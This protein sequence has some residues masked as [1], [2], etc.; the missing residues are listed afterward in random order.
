LALIQEQFILEVAEAVP[1]EVHEV[2]MVAVELVVFQVEIH[3]ELL[4]G[5]PILEVVAVEQTVKEKQAVLAY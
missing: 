2:D 4:Q 5:K 3:L 1:T